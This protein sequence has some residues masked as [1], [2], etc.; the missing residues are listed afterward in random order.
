MVT[1]I[2]LIGGFVAKTILLKPKP[3]TAAQVAAAAK[4]AEVKLDNL[5]AS[6][7]GLPTKPLPDA[8]GA[9][10][11]AADSKAATTTTTSTPRPPTRPARSTRSTRSRS[12]S[13]P[14]TT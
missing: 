5:C 4:L 11:K 1:V 7:N 3:P 14:A 10:P 12:T 13:R 8:T 6:H 9:D 2:V